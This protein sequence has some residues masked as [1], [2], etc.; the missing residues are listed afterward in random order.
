MITALRITRSIQFEVG[1]AFAI[2]V[3]N[4]LSS[5]LLSSNIIIKIHRNTIVP[6]ALF[7]FETWSLALREE[8][9]L[10]LSE[11][12]LLDKIFGLKRNG[13]ERE[14]RRLHKEKLGDLYSSS[15]KI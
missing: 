5:S 3:Q 1:N 2:S 7:G 15:N 13:L 6:V 4:C 14:C 9:E 8:R 10:R 12:R 11:N